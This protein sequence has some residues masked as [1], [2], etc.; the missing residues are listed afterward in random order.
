M[1]T[2]EVSSG[3]ARNVNQLDQVKNTN[4]LCRVRNTRPNQLSYVRP[5]ILIS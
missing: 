5:G 4:Q 3:Q 1:N 2:G